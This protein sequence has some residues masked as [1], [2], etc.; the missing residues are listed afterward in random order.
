MFFPSFSF[1]VLFVDMIH[2]RSL[3]V[4][5]LL[6]L[7]V[8][9][10]WVRIDVDGDRRTCARTR[11]MAFGS[12]SHNPDWG[13][14]HFFPSLPFRPYPTP[15]TASF[16]HIRAHSAPLSPSFVCTLIV[17]RFEAIPPLPFPR[18]PH[19]SNTNQLKNSL[20]SHCSISLPL[21]K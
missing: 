18:T 19:Q 4:A 10:R 21:M 8:G 17:T 1:C 14:F 11:S 7:D 16:P 15:R 3:R 5:V 9:D 20:I 2:M 6:E 12:L 13:G